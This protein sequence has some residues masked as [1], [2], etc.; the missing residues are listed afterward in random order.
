MIMMLHGTSK[1]PNSVT[2]TYRTRYMTRQVIVPS[3]GLGFEA[4]ETEQRGQTAG[5]LDPGEKEE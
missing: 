5:G 2:T 1:I 4:I 3:G